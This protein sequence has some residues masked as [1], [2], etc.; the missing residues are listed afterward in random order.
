MN[1]K[2]ISAVISVVLLLLI[3][4]AII[5]IAFG[6]FVGIFNKATDQ[7]SS[8]IDNL[9]LNKIATL[10]SALCGPT[11]APVADG[12]LTV[13]IRAAGSTNL[14]I[15]D[16]TIYLGGVL[17]GSNT[18]E[19]T[20]GQTS[21]FYIDLTNPANNGGTLR[22]TSPVTVKTRDPAGTESTKTI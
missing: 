3:T 10:E 21:Q 4:V 9:N 20:A 1:R 14:D 7:S 17:V 8:A 13:S 2:G 19:I 22:C 18:A 12:N 15:G 6:W 16:V 11:L 5:G